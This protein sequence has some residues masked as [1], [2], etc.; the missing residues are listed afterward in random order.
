LGVRVLVNPVEEQVNRFKGTYVHKAQFFAVGCGQS[1]TAP[2]ALKNT[3][4]RATKELVAR[5]AEAFNVQPL[6]GMHTT[7]V[8]IRVIRGVA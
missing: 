1:C 8:M 5:F 3:A 2:L 6:V 7:G 4:S